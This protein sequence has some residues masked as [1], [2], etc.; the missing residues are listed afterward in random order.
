M[1]KK[2]ILLFLAINFLCSVPISAAKLETQSKT[3]SLVER[4]TEKV[5]SVKTL[6]D[7][8]KNGFLTANGKTDII[9]TVSYIKVF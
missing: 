5:A 9:K 8:V 4:T 1:I 6:T 7:A 3:I 2:T